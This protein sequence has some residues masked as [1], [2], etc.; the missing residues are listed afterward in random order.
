MTIQVKVTFDQKNSDKI[1][2]IEESGNQFGMPIR[3]QAGESRVFYLHNTNSLT[4]K[5]ESL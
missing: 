1:L 4:V 2:I 5:E 3:L